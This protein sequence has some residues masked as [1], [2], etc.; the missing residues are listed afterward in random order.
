MEKIHEK[1][2][3]EQEKL[4]GLLEKKAEIDERIKES[5]NRIKKYTMM[6]NE[7]KFTEVNDVISSTGLSLE[8]VMLAIKSGDLLSLQEKIE[9]KDNRPNESSSLHETNVESE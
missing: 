9:S 4:N 6:I 2:A 3:K 8:E 1:R 7:Q 5:E